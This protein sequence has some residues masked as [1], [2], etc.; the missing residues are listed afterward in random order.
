MHS[1]GVKSVEFLFGQSDRRV[2]QI[3]RFF[4]FDGRPAEKLHPEG[5]WFIIDGFGD[6][7]QFPPEFKSNWFVVRVQFG[8]WYFASS[9]KNKYCCF[10]ME[11]TYFLLAL[12]G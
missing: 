9:R 8:A 1:P 6:C 5:F 4:S 10:S 2:F 3:S 7:G 12:V 11:K